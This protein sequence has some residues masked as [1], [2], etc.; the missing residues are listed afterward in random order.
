MTRSKF[1]RSALLI[2]MC[3]ATAMMPGVPLSADSPPTQGVRIT[4]IGSPT[5]KPVDLHLFSAPIGTAATGYAEFAVTALGLLPPPNHVFHPDLLVGPGAP[6][7]PPYDT[8]LANGVAD[9]GFHEGVHFKSSEFSNGEGVFLVWMNVPDPGTTGSS[10]DFSSGSIVPN[11][12]FPMHVLGVSY[13]NDQVFD[14]FLADILIPPLDE[15]LSPPFD[16][17]GHSHF[18]VF[19]ADNA[20]FGPPG[21]KLNGSYRYQ[22]TMTDQSG[23]G[24]LIEAHFTVAP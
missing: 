18:P 14:P 23:N 1:V 2:L 22:Y 19:S 11:S 7:A 3:G 8:E 17:D 9:L 13:H 4:R 24:W 12:L 5:W 10:P 6:H 15:N 20:D 21:A 16:V